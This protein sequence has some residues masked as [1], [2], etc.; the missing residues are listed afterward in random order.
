VNRRDLIKR[1]LALGA[2]LAGSKGTAAATSSGSGATRTTGRAARGQTAAGGQANTA[3]FNAE[4]IVVGSG[5]GGGTVAARLAE[6]GF[7]VLLLEAGGDPRQLEGSD[8][9]NPGTNALPEDYDV[10]AFHSLATEN[11]ALKWDFFVRHYADDARQRRDPKYL[12]TFN[13][14]P[15]DGVLYPRA[16]TL[17]GCTAHNAMIL[18][19]PHNSDWD[20]LADLTG[21][22]SWRADHMRTYFERLENC[23]HRPF[24]RLLSKIG[25]N[26]SR[27]GWGGWLSTDRAI[28]VAAL[29]DRDLRSTILQ[30]TK[31]ALTAIGGIRVDRARLDFDDPNDWRAVEESAF[32]IRYTP[33]TTDNH[34]RVGTR[35]RVL[36]VQRRYP[37]RLKIELNA[38]AT[39]V[40]LD[41]SNRA[42]GVEYLKGERLYRAHAKPSEG[43]GELRQARASR[44][45]VLA[46][47]AFNTPQLLM[48]SGIG[49]R[50]HL[51][52]HGIPVRIALP[53]VGQNL[54]DRYEVAVLNR[55][56]FD[57]W[58]PLRGAGFTRN[59][60]QYREWASNRRGIFS[61]NG[62]LLSVIV[63]SSVEQPVPDLFCYGLIGDFTGY[64]PGYS[65]LVAKN[66]N[67]LT[68]V[69]LKGHTNNTAGSV[70][71]RSRDPRDAP[72]I[73]FRYFEEGNDGRRQ[74]IQAV[75]QG[76]KLVRKMAEGLKRRGLIEKE[77]VPGDDTKSDEALTEFV[78]NNA[79]GHHASCSC[80]IGPM[81][82]GGVLTSD[83]KVHGAQGLRV[84]DA[85]VFP[86]VPGLFIVSAIYMIGE[87][88]A[89]VIAADAKKP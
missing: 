27:H 84:V 71:L 69:V 78:R 41:D 58:E 30:S 18:V 88:A 49:P 6:S 57:A 77:E 55:M 60:A 12:A 23:R 31:D 19:C 14:K 63:P 46:G 34:A 79:W 61:T 72:L 20:Q 16:G 54:Q 45:V 87:K 48:L 62:V 15:V 36:D 8:P 33:L 50:A 65:T 10:P 21:D 28:P 39:R 67:C 5:A 9:Q 68:W 56:S 7:R 4:Y 32:G 43:G 35:E 17:G 85:S 11:E 83:F 89:E 1:G 86:R 37:G 70:T 42:V 13:S 75:V 25:I 81:E 73:N 64:F 76:V 24:E 40:L 82:S 80:P 47:G 22:P 66:P 74:D 26:P 29:K 2:W 44:E 52:S 51:E 59:D 38:L 53:G 3:D